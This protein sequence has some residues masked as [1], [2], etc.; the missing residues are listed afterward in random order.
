MDYIAHQAPLSMGFPRQGYWSRLPFLSPGDLPYLVKK[1]K[2]FGEVLPQHHHFPKII[3]MRRHTHHKFCQPVDEILSKEKPVFP[4]YIDIK[5]I[6]LLYSK[7]KPQENKIR[8][9]ISLT[10]G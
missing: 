2:E 1:N 8:N 6:T 7:Y 3:K 10:P 5:K 4:G 9:K